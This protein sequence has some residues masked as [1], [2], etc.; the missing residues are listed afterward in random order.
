[1]EISREEVRAEIEALKKEGKRVQEARM[2][3]PA[4]V[5]PLARRIFGE[6]I[7]IRP[8]DNLDINYICQCFCKMSK[9]S[10][11]PY[12]DFEKPKTQTKEHCTAQLFY[13]SYDT[14]KYI[15]NLLKP[16]LVY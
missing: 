15:E 7:E 12:I 13:V 8:K 10:L 16:I 1:M 2:I 5:C 6:S 9:T 14:R 11:L 4:G 3:L